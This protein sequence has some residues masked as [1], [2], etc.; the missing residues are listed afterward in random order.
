MHNVG[1]MCTVDLFPVPDCVY[2]SPIQT[3]SQ[4]SCTNQDTGSGDTQSRYSLTYF[5]VH[6]YK[7]LDVDG[8]Q[9]SVAPFRIPRRQPMLRHLLRSEFPNDVVFRIGNHLIT[10]SSKLTPALVGEKCVEPTLMDYEGRKALVF[11]FGVRC[12]D[13]KLLKYP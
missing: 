4:S 11:V 8:V 6:P 2:G 7:S 13:I 5:P 12:F 3:F 9:A 1:V 10:E